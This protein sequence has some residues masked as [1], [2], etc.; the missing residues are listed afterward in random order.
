MPAFPS[1]VAVRVKR[2]LT[3]HGAKHDTGEV[4][5]PGQVHTRSS[6]GCN[7]HDGYDRW[8]PGGIE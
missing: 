5:S 2:N 4:L 8:F 7:D 1:T 6:A 3:S